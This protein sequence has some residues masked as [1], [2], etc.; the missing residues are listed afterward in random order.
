MA[1]TAKAAGLEPLQGHGIR[2]GATLEYL[3]WGVS[4]EVMK[5]KG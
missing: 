4:F 1:M 5:A 3:L 2:I